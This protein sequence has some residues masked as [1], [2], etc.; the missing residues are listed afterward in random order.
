VTKAI[1]V[2]TTVGVLVERVTAVLA[3]AEIAEA[4]TEARDI[5]AVAAGQGRLWPRLHTHEFLTADVV[6]RARQAADRR[7]TGMPFAYA[8]GRAAFRHLTLQVD[9][10]VLIPRQETELLIDLVLK[11]RVL[12]GGV[13][14]D[15]CTGSGAI[16]LALASEGNFDRVIGTDVDAGAIAVARSNAPDPGPQ[17]PGPKIEFRVGNLV[18]PLA[19]ETLDVLV[20][21]PPY[22]AYH[23]A[24]ELP[25]LV[26]DWEPSHA[27]FSGSNGL[28]ATRQIVRGAGAL[29]CMGGLL[30]LEVDS[31]RSIDV[32]G[33]VAADGAFT[34]VQLYQDLTGRDR[35]VLATRA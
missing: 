13:V 35:F 8:V 32:T 21:N 28:D 1:D 15:V 29:L 19:G 25:A 17:A 26:R 4:G 9:E 23:E 18:A 27:L 7:A 2:D 16:A 33:L 24:V 20:S 6:M 22:I 14:A 11:H 5:V 30:A 10:R 34:N 3:N 12:P 31:R